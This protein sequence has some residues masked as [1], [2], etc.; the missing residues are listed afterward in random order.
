MQSTTQLHS[1]QTALTPK[2]YF[3]ALT[4]IRAVAAYLVFLYHFNP[5]AASGST[6]LAHHII[7]HFHIGVGIFFVLSGFLI[8][9]RYAD[10]VTFSR[11]WAARYLRNR[12][13][14]IYPLYFILTLI[15]FGAIGWDTRFDVTGIW[16]NYTSLDK[17]VVFLSNITFLRGFF[18][19]LKF[20]GI[21]QG[22]SLTVEETFYLL[23]PFMLYGLLQNPKR[24]LIYG[25]AFLSLGMTIVFLCASWA[26]MGFFSSLGFMFNFTFFGR[27]TEF[28]AGM[29]L[30]V[31]VRKYGNPVRQGIMFTLLGITAI[32]LFI[33]F[34]SLSAIDLDAALTP[35]DISSI[36]ANYLL[37]LTGICTLF[38]GLIREQTLLQRLLESKLA[39]LLGKSSYAFYLVHLGVFAVALDLYLTTNIGIKFILLNILSIALYRF[40]E[41][42][43]HKL[44]T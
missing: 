12:V 34:S 4:G 11:A 2:H 42:P 7:A 9:A 14:R 38:Y 33:V 8:T 6:A 44:L 35:L 31:F 16:R 5:F 13:A 26:P 40:I 15:T 1:V 32:I 24:L 27:C 30:A 28:L 3:P 20:T 39:D 10:R 21:A 19:G 18:D 41:K 22:W 17:L 25:A 29:A 37:L 36:I 23:A 43:I